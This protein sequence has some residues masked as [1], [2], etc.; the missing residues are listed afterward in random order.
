MNLNF[1]NIFENHGDEIDGVPIVLTGSAPDV[2]NC[3]LSPFRGN[4]VSFPTNI[5]PRKIALN[6]LYPPVEEDGGKAVF[7][8]YGLR[9]IEALLLEEFDEK[10]IVVCHP[11]NLERFVGRNTKVVGITSMD[12]MGLA[13]V[14]ATYSSILATGKPMTKAEFKRVVT[15]PSIIK[16]K[17]KI[18]VGGAGTWQIEKTKMQKVYNIDTLVYGEGE[19]V[20]KDLFKKAVENKPLPKIVFGKKPTIEQI[21]I[22]KNASVFGI[23]EIT[24]GCGRGCQFCSPNM[25]KKVS[26][27]MERILKEVEINV[28]HGSKLI[29]PNSEDIF[30]YNSNGLIPNSNAVVDLFKKIADFN[31]VEYIHLSHA[32]LAPVV[33]SP[34]MVE[35]LSNIFLEKTQFQLNGKPF[36]TVE[37]GIETGSIRLIEKYMKGKA[38][39]YNIKNW[40]EIVIEAIGILNDNSWYPLC[41][42]MT[43]L[44]GETEEDTIE[45]LILLDELKNRKIFYVPLLFVPLKN[46]ALSRAQNVDLKELT[47]AQ[48]DFFATC[49]RHNINIWRPKHIP[50]IMLGSLFAYLF[51]YRWKHGKK[52]FYPTM[53]YACFPESFLNKWVY[54]G[55]EKMHCMDRERN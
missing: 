15:H 22:I 30:L 3:N 10:D 8:P 20:V 42:L 23:V 32:S 11:E 13:Y 12:P 37:I 25:R 27:P 52:A 43:G 7:A 49:W 4:I 18:I 46:C 41:T 51:Y 1:L 9:K 34:K 19:L 47:P 33:Y 16:Y 48:W 36:V 31:G 39:P 5:L 54:K 21:P 45:T 40:K 50:K 53:K 26:F 55:C 24:R 14:G 29:F 38:L 35:D 44:P 28:K 2:S 17:P 6:L